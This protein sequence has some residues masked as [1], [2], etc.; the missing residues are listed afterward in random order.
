MIETPPSHLFRM[1]GVGTRAWGCAETGST[2][3]PEPQP[4]SQS[5]VVQELGDQEAGDQPRTPPPRS[6]E[7]Q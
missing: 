4:S 5:A 3:G 7:P 1:K 6:Q 2:Q